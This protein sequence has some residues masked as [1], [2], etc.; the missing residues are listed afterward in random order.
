MKIYFSRINSVVPRFF[1]TVLVYIATVYL[2]GTEEYSPC[3]GAFSVK[4]LDFN[5]SRLA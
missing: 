4:C 2:R 1:F 3:L 5:V